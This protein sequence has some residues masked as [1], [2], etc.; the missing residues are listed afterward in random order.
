M[1]VDIDPNT[2]API[3]MSEGGTS[4][5]FTPAND[6]QTTEGDSTQAPQETNK[7][8]SA[9][10]EEKPME[11]VMLPPPSI[12]E[13]L[14]TKVAFRAAVL[15]IANRHCSDSVSR[16]KCADEIAALLPDW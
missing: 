3:V 6:A 10:A 4:A 12:P 2:G 7:E 13:H 1:S 5:S 11:V 9:Q 14:K 15:E 8:T 16:L